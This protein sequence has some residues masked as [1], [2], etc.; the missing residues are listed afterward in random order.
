MTLDL[1]RITVY[2][3]VDLSDTFGNRATAE[4]HV[5]VTLMDLNAYILFFHSCKFFL[6]V[7]GMSNWRRV[8]KGMV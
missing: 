3:R 1:P 7:L 4:H 5:L 8:N 2:F 6:R